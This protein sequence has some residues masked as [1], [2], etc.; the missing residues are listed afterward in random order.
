MPFIRKFWYDSKTKNDDLNLHNGIQAAILGAKSIRIR[1]LE[2]PY[3][4]DIWGINIH[5]HLILN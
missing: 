4:S 3:Y 2:G 1:N 5:Y